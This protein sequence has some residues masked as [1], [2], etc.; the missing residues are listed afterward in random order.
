[1]I[2]WHLILFTGTTVIKKGFK[3]KSCITS[4]QL[5]KRESSMSVNYI[6]E[7]FHTITPYIMAEN[8]SGLIDFIKKAFNAEEMNRSAMPDGT[9]VNATIKIGDS[10]MMLADPRTCEPQPTSFYMYVTD[11]D[12]AYKQA[13]EAGGESLM[14]PGDQFYGDRNAG[15]KD[16]FGNTWWIATHIEDVSPEEMQRRQADFMKKQ[17]K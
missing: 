14:E 17:Q 4:F 13:L 16:P 11:T 8:A 12:A 7:G 6:P 1:M 10:I 3:V 9:I 2:E 5:F 15:V